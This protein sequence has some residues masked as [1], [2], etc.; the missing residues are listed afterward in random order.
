[1][2]MQ[3]YFVTG[4]DTGVGKTRVACDLLRSAQDNG[5]KTIG[6]KPVAAGCRI[7]EKTNKPINY[8]ALM[9]MSAMTEKLSYDQVNPVALLPAIAPH[10]ALAQS[11]QTITVDDLMQHYQELL[12]YAA[13]VYVIEGAGGWRVPLNEK[14]TLADFVKCVACSVVLVVGLRLGCINH[15]LLTVEAIRADGLVL[16]G[17]IANQVDPAMTC[18]EENI[19][20]LQ[21]RIHAPYWGFIPYDQAG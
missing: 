8:D 3:I 15:A 10:L 20:A 14:E 6:F 11:N 7:G 9:L 21:A 2:S 19:E 17:W 13:D 4:T 18:V 16:A 1:M 12:N 5:L